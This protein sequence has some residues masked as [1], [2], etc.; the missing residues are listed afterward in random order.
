[1]AGGYFMFSDFI[2][3]LRALFRRH[4]VEA[5][6]DAELRGH[7]ENEI[8][9]YVDAGVPRSEVA[10]RARLALGGLEQI[11][12]QCRESRGTRWLEDFAQDL[13]YAFRM[14]RKN[15]GFTV[16]AIFTLAIGI[17]ANSAAFGL[18]DSALLRA[19]PFFQP[20]R[21]VHVWT[22]DAAGDLHTPSPAE[23]VALQKNTQAF[24]QVTGAGWMDFYLE[25]GASAVSLNGFLVTANWLPTLGIQPVLGRN[26]LDA[27]QTSGRDAVAMLSYP[28]WRT[29]FHA[30]PLVVGKRINLNRRNVTIIGILPQSLGPYYEGV[31]VLAPLVLD[32]YKEGGNR[33]SGTVR[34]QI[35]ARL[36]SGVT[37]QQAR[38]ETEVI[39]RQLRLNRDAAD[40]AGHLVVEDFA[41]MFRHPGPTA[42]NARR[43]I[44]ITVCAAGLVLLIA[45]ANVA[46]LLLARGVKR[47]RE[48]A[49][50]AALG[51]SRR[52]VIRQLL[53]ESSLLFLC[54]A[55][56]GLIVLQWSRDLITTAV[57]GLAPGTYLQTDAR[58]L[59]VTAGVALLTALFFGMIPALHATRVNLNDTLKDT[60]VHS[61]AG[62]PSR[63]LRNLLVVF[64]IALGMV[65]LVCFG[66]LF[67]SLRNV[68]SASVGYDPRNI[69]TATLNL[70]PS[71]YAEPSARIRV[72]REA[73]EHARSMPG[74]E[75]AGITGSLPMYGA[76]SA[77]FNIE[78]SSPQTAPTQQEVY[79][80]ATSPGYFSTLKVP[81]L[82]GRSFQD[83][84]S[85]AS[86]PVAIVNETFV[87]Q[88]FPRANPVGRHIAFADSPASWIEIVGVVSD[89]SQRNPEEDWRPLAYFPVSQM[90]PGQWSLAVRTRAS[91]DFSS[92]SQN[93][94]DWLGR[95]DSQLFWRFG[96]MQEDIQGSESLSLRRPIVIL[97]ASFGSL[98]LIL[99]LVGIFGVTAYSVTERTREIGIRVALGA[100]RIE[101]ARVVL[102][103][104][105]SVACAGLVMGTLGAFA[106]TR[107]FPTAHIGWSGSGIFLYGVARTDASTYALAAVILTGVTIAASWIPALRA[108]R[109][110]PMV[111][112]RHE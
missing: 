32:S 100:V 20:E 1:M 50:R 63:T 9:K 43:G 30:D 31:D 61:P 24:E 26:F 40:H 56:L 48:M 74:V 83:T 57:S 14:L 59:L 86:S 6:L 7:L 41:E 82:S 60:G 36:K 62:T 46:S 8:E 68:E 81:L 111:A 37:L 72:I 87:K 38:A 19:L 21:L 78:P 70:P 23:Y 42:Q 34:V 88:Y 112:L 95:V 12:E 10:R 15:P 25:E 105:L 66:L 101:I 51:S 29:R 69:L 98:A 99:A 55:A 3:R 64:Q 108:T 52:R 89:F 73:L 28:C 76:D 44:W 4:K 110:D 67:H 35:V 71:R 11:K 45:C 103:E 85:P 104:A 96:T 39:A 54:G 97:F 84:D 53:T 109:I 13:R 79:F 16:V 33:R 90:P 91:A 94:A 17:G 65:L 102:R 18:V 58:V 77:Q 47:Q 2:F 80:V 27:E 75:S 5:E 107:F 106:I 92:S 49:L 93:L 22:T